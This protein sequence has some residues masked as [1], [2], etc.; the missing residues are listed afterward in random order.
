MALEIEWGM[1]HRANKLAET[2]W[3]NIEW[4]QTHFAMIG[5]GCDSKNSPPIPWLIP[6]SISSNTAC[7]RPPAE[8]LR[9]PGICSE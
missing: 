2:G 6:A 3:K 8:S 7:L 9:P 1:T 4:V 5:S